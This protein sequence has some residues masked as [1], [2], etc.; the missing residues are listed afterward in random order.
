MRTLG[1]GVVIVALWISASTAIAQGVSLWVNGPR[2]GYS[3]HYVASYGYGA[4]LAVGYGYP[5]WG[6]PYASY[7]YGGYPIRYRYSWPYYLDT[8]SGYFGPYVAPPIYVPPEQ[9]GFGPQAVRNLLGLGPVQRPIVNRNIIVVPPAARDNPVDRGNAVNNGVNVAGLRVRES[10]AAARERAR[11]FLEFGDQQ[12][13][14][15]NLA[16]A[17]DR[18]KKAADAAPDLAEPYFRLGHTLA[19]MGRYQQAADSFGRG[20]NLQPDWPARGL[21]LAELYR[22]KDA[23]R[24][25][26]LDLL[27]RAAAN[28]PDD[29][30]V[31]FVAGVQFFFDGQTELARG[32]FERAKT[33]GFPAAYIEP[34]LKSWRA[35]EAGELDI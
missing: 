26:T 12:F 32:F 27:K 11:Q 28:Q 10:N 21:P 15:P 1:I 34:F 2:Y 5:G 31:Q 24:L 3:S 20:L 4:P 17:Y 16:A 30:H 13:A 8:G 35:A 25:A 23:A 29:E 9:L 18:Y 6:Y 33:L 22:D 7:P 14:A 19:A